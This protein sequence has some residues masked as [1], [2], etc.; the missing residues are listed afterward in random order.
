MSCTAIKRAFIIALVIES[1]SGVA[2]AG[3]VIQ[4]QQSDSW[5]GIEADLTSVQAK[6]NVVTVKFTLRNTG[7]QKASVQIKYQG[8]YLMDTA[9]QKKYYVLK[10]ADGLFIAGP[11]YDKSDGGRFW[12]DIAPGAAKGMWIKFPQPTDKVETVTI[13][14]PGVFPFEDI[15]LPK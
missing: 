1:L 12:S 7:S 15:I 13:L 14:L 3:E 2:L 9:N 11:M 5:D 6:D 10:D 4:T 8:C